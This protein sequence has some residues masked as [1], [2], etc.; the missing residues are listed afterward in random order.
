MNFGRSNVKT[1]GGC[2]PIGINDAPRTRPLFLTDPVEWERQMVVKREKEAREREVWL[3][4]SEGQAHTKREAEEKTRQAELLKRQLEA[5]AKE[6]A[7]QERFN[8]LKINPTVGTV[9]TARGRYYVMVSENPK[10][11]GLFSAYALLRTEGK[12]PN[13]PEPY[14]TFGNHGRWGLKVFLS[15]RSITQLEKD[16]PDSFKYLKDQIAEAKAAKEAVAKKLAEDAAARAR[17]EIPSLDLD[18]EDYLNSGSN[19]DRGDSGPYT[20]IDVAVPI[21]ITGFAQSGKSAQGE[22]V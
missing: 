21:K 22:L 15:N 9:I 16:H 17:G 18:H 11:P 4:T 12:Y 13:D 19:R 5:K 1:G 8:E 3:L 7:W 6:S 20:V 2:R 10:R 14:R